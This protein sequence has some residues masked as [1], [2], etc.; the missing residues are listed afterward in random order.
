MKMQREKILDLLREINPEPDYETREDIFDGGL[1]ESLDIITLVTELI[2]AFDVEI[3]AE[4]IIPANFNS[5]AGI[6]A[7]ITRLQEEG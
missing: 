5:L 1:L 3:R 2:D 7:L 4:E 6:E